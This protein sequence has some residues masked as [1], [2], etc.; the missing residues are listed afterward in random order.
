[1]ADELTRDIGLWEQMPE[2]RSTI[3]NYYLLVIAID[4]YQNGIGQLNNPVSDANNIV[5]LLTSKYKFTA[6][7]A[8][9]TRTYCL[10]NENATSANIISR[11]KEIQAK[12]GENDALLI[13]CAGHGEIGA[14][15]QYYFIPYNGIKTDESTW[16]GVNSF[17]QYFLKYPERKK[18]RDLLVVLDC[19]YA[20]K[21]SEGFSLQ[22]GKRFSRSVLTSCLADQKAADGLRNIGSAFADAFV[23]LLDSNTLPVLHID[24]LELSKKFAFYY[25][26]QTQKKP[27]QEI[28]YTHLPTETGE[29]EFG[30]ELED[31]KRPPIDI[32]AKAFITH[33]NFHEQKT[34]FLRH[35]YKPGQHDYLI[36]STI[37]KSIN[38]HKLQAKVL[39]EQIKSVT[40]LFDL[41]FTCPITFPPDVVNL[42]IWEALKVSLGITEKE[43]IKAFCARNICNRLL[44]DHSQM[45]FNEPLIIYYECRFQSAEQ[46]KKIIEFCRELIEV[47]TETKK[48]S[49]YEN[50][51]FKKLLFFIADTRD[52]DN[53]FITRD[54]MVNTIGELP[55]II[56]ARPV[57]DLE[58][59][60]AID[61]LNKSKEEIF[62]ENFA[63]LSVDCYFKNCSSYDIESFILEVGKDLEVDAIQLSG[64]LWNYS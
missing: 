54:E 8:Q 1:M 3:D 10:F 38:V 28:L 24:K 9:D 19:C 57:S 58:I 63:N 50:K 33:L 62:S 31:K 13:F 11:L 48:L 47:I 49:D 61:W 2:Q 20:G 27:P 36:I 39:F 4:S 41:K 15:D 59:G 5:R 23:S 22:N 35:Y 45:T 56:V 55:K 44:V 37:C 46:S 64:Q 30:F 34:D 12:I 18:C 60:F 40:K 6:P 52:G 29:S 7:G 43:S 51:S 17:H 26:R 16:F 53:S 25:T 21:I 32:L 14:D 42:S